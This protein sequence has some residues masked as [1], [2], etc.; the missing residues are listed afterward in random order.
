MNSSKYSYLGLELL[1]YLVG[2][3]GLNI[4]TSWDAKNAAA[5]VDIR[6]DSV[7]ELLHYL[8]K[9]G[10]IRRL[11][12]GLYAVSDESGF[13]TPPHDFEIVMALVTPSAISHWTALHY[14]HLTQ[15][16]PNKIFA[17]TP[18]GTSI[19]RSL[20][21]E[22]YHYIQI[23]PDIFFGFKKVWIGQSQIQITNLERTLLDGLMTPQHCG[24]FQEILGAFKIAKK[25]LN[26]T[27]LIEY[28]TRLDVAVVKRLGWILERLG[29]SEDELQG[30]QKVTVRGYRKLDPTG[31]IKGVCNR[32]WMIRENLG[33]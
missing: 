16:M 5:A 11:K 25:K 6:C 30:L 27:K 9:L 1:R 23:K 26:L 20:S 31:P 28:A 3:Q 10:W 14:H 21:K 32:K 7:A 15:Q 2:S 8:Q 22:H 24:G 19:P 33:E 4:F 29:F 17:I 18:T 12:R 13:G